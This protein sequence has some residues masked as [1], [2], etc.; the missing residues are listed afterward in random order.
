M[1]WRRYLTKRERGYIK[2]KQYFDYLDRLRNSGV[3]NM[4]GAASY[5]QREFPELGFNHAQAGYILREWICGH[6]QEGRDA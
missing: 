1:P 6:R 2:M 3:T 5:L 4:Y